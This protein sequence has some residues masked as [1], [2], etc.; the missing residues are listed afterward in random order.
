VS[1]HWPPARR[2][3]LTTRRRRALEGLL[4]LSPWALGLALFVVGPMLV[5]LYLSLTRYD[6][7]SPPAFVGVD[8]YAMALTG[9]KLF[10]SSLGRT[11]AFAFVAVP[12]GSTLS[13]LLAVLLNQSLRGTSVYR[14]FFFLPSLTPAVAAAILWSW[15]LQPEAGLVNYLLSL[16]G[17]KGPPWLGSAEWAIPAIVLIALWQNAGGN[18]MMIYL[19]GLQGVPPELYEAARIDGAGAWSTFRHVTVPLISPTIFFNL[20]LGVIGALKVF[21]IAF[22]A[23][24]GGPAYATWF[25]ALHIYTQAFQYFELGYAAALSWLFF[26]ILLAFTAIQFGLSRRWVYY[27]GEGR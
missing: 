8:N 7:V 15:V 10:W 13:L 23:T 18:R 26:V 14:T 9:D 4:Y 22:V 12:L 16:V 21:T 6:I 17:I 5:S 24:K 3:W 19:A 27:A 2:R 1:A 20:V 11:F 25:F